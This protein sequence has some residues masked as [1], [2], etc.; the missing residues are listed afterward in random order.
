MSFVDI[1]WSWLLSFRFGQI[2]YK[3]MI[4][5]NG[6]DAC[7]TVDISEKSTN[8]VMN[9]V[10]LLDENV[11]CFAANINIKPYNRVWEFGQASPIEN[12]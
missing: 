11:I 6:K 12:R 3:H 7:I 9:Y 1:V 4:W 5:I 10:K 2:F 8:K